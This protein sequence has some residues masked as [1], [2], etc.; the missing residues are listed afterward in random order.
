MTIFSCKLFNTDEWLT[1][2]NI[3]LSRF[4]PDT[5]QTLV[6][7]DENQIVKLPRIGQFNLKLFQ[8]PQ[9]VGR[10]ESPECQINKSS[11]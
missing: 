1:P 2:D 4:T 9:I 7:S 3:Y 11:A 10:S 8:N 5:P 6:P